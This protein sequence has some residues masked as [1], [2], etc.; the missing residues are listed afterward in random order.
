VRQSLEAIVKANG[1]L[2]I[3]AKANGILQI[4]AKAKAKATEKV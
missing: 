4:K 3:K 2:Q 1:I